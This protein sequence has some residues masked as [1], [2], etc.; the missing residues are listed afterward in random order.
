MFVASS[1]FDRI[2][3]AVAMA[4]RHSLSSLQ[5][6]ALKTELEKPEYVGLNAAGVLVAVNQKPIIDNPEPAARVPRAAI[7]AAEYIP[8]INRVILRGDSLTGGARDIWLRVKSA[9]EGMRFQESVNLEDPDVI[10]GL[11]VL[12]QLGLLSIREGEAISQGDLL[13]TAPDP[14]WQPKVVGLSVAEQVT[15]VAWAMLTP[16]DIEAAELL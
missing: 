14:A 11:S 5:L 8:I 7:S 1:L 13:R 3:C 9:A 6:A 16:E 2:G 12:D 10:L 4:N 15:G